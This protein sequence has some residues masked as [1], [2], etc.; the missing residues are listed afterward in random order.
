MNHSATEVAGKGAPPGSSNANGTQPRGSYANAAK[1]N[2]TPELNSSPPEWTKR[3]KTI[4]KR[5]DA[6]HLN[7]H[8]QSPNEGSITFAIP[9]SIQRL[10][11]NVVIDIIAETLDTTLSHTDVHPTRTGYT[12]NVTINDLEKRKRALTEGIKIQERTVL[13][14]I[15]APINTLIT[16]LNLRHVPRDFTFEQFNT[17]FEKYGEI[18]EIGKYFRMVRGSEMTTGECF[19]LLHPKEL[20]LKIPASMTTEGSDI[21]IH[22]PS[23]SS[24]KATTAKHSTKKATETTTN[25]AAAKDSSAARADT[26]SSQK[27][28]RRGGRKRT[29]TNRTQYMDAEDADGNPITHP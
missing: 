29:K 23:T 13:P 15:P 11:P 4:F 27:N 12:V 19:I 6:A 7:L 26:G 25:E 8:V 5:Q 1:N 3:C 28:K 18:L 2:S 14:C 22:I 16:K 9:V 20:N 17:L 21:T 10:N 24:D